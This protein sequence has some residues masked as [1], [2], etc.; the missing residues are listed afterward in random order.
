MKAVSI[1][2]Y[3]LSLPRY[4]IRLCSVDEQAP[5]NLGVRRVHS[6]QRIHVHDAQRACGYVCTLQ[7]STEVVEP[8]VQRGIS[9]FD[10]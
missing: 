7:N 5:P 9:Q 3:S 2:C 4:R 10:G 1:S 6:E 8:T